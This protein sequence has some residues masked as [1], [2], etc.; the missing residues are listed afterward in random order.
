MAL[1]P[2]RRKPSGRKK[3]TAARVTADSAV[4]VVGIEGLDNPPLGRGEVVQKVTVG[5]AKFNHR[6][7]IRS[8]GDRTNINFRH[9]PRRIERPA[10]CAVSP[11]IS[12]IR[13]N[14]LY[15]ASLS[16]RASEPVLI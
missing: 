9:Q 1:I 11:S 16:E 6:R 8:G 15:F 7:E 3:R 4:F 14:W 2:R 13:I 10:Y 5:P 12:S